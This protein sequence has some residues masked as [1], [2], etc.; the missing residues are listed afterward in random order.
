MTQKRLFIVS[1]RLPIN[2]E[3]DT[4]DIQLK[5]S[6]G[7]MVAAVSSSLQQS[8]GNRDD[9][10]EFYWAGF[11]GCTP[12][13]WSQAVNRLRSPIFNY[14]PVFINQPVYEAF[15]GGFAKSVI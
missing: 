2:I 15:Y 11:P 13:F 3:A 12:A 5:Q 7:D 8:A 10:H 6:I 4:D 14:L 1:N 9:F